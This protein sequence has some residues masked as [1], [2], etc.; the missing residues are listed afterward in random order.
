M[1]NGKK[2]K[3]KTNNYTLLSFFKEMR[4]KKRAEGLSKTFYD[5]GLNYSPTE[6][7]YAKTRA[8]VK[9]ESQEKSISSSLSSSLPV[10]LL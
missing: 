6:E 3:K 8:S 10:S 9:N 7:Q 1:S 2:Q 4:G 5:L